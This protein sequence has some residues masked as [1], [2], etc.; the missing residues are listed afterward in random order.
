ML[1]RALSV[2]CKVLD[3]RNVEEFLSRNIQVEFS[4]F[5]LSHNKSVYLIMEVE[6][7]MTGGSQRF[8][9]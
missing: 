7:F 5:F 6:K 4:V 2:G 3:V 1:P 8:L 9:E